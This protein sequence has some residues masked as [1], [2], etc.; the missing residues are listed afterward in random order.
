MFKIT[1]KLE[2]TDTLFFIIYNNFMK[3]KKQLTSS[4]E[5]QLDSPEWSV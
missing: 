4:N 1:P 2:N 5:R 3:A